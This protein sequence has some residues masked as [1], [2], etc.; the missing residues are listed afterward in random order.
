VINAVLSW[1][2]CSVLIQLKCVML[3]SSVSTTGF[4]HRAEATKS[5]KALGS[6]NSG[7]A[8]GRVVAEGFFF[9]CCYYYIFLI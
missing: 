1:R 7:I 8:V 2:V 6:D 4:I 9:Y 3:V 5:L